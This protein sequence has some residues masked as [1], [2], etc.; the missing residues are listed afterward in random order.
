[1]GI[2]KLLIGALSVAL[3]TSR[4]N[5]NDFPWEKP[6]CVNFWAAPEPAYGTISVRECFS[7]PK[8]FKLPLPPLRY[9]EVTGKAPA[10]LPAAS[11]LNAEL[12]ANV[13]WPPRGTVPAARFLATAS[14]LRFKPPFSAVMPGVGV[15]I[16]P[17]WDTQGT[18]VGF[19]GL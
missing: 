4:H 6:P 17:S 13:T 14:R 1:M 7:V 16:P 18:M 15:Y 9:S 3:A 8:A 11:A 10:T 19:Q 2:F 5:D 12:A